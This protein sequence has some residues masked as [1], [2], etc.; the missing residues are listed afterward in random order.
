MLD[1]SVAVTFVNALLEAA[2]NK[3]LLDQTENDL[4][5]VSDTIEKH[6]DFK[7]MLLHPSITRKQKKDTIKIVFGESVSGLMVNFLYLLVDR[8]REQILEL[9]PDVYRQVVDE[10]KGVIRA[11][12]QTTIPIVG[13]RLE[14]LKDGLK[15]LTGKIVEVEVIENPQILGGL[16]VEIGNKMIDGSVAN[17]LKNLR[18][19]LLEIRASY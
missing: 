14:N 13:E 7:K 1:K 11:K 3:G 10:K 6:D 5:L 2:V 4:R 9:I 19:K 15:K 18:S 17:R 8:R 12:V 16:V